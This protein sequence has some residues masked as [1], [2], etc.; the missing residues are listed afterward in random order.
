RTVSKFMAGDFDGDGKD[1]IIGFNGG[2]ELM[3]WRSTSTA[4]AFGFAPYKSLGTGWGVFTQLLPLADY[5]G[6]GKN[7]GDELMVWRSSST[8]TAFG[9]APYKSLGTGWGIFGNKLLTSAPTD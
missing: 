2:D 1:D 6:D 9:F 7:G 4:T 3:I 8:A 5:D